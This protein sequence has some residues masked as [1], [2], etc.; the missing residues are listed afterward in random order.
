MKRPLGNIAAALVMLFGFA[1]VTTTT[2]AQGN[3]VY[4][5]DDITGPNT[6]SGFSVASNGTLTPVPGSPFATGG[7]GTGVCCLNRPTIGNVGNFLFTSNTGSNNVSVFSINAGTGAL[8][9]VAGS[10]FATG[11]SGDPFGIALSPTPDGMFLMAANSGSNN[12][13]VFSIAG[14]GALTPIAGSP[15]PTLSIPFGT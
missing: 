13:T 6:V 5:N 14:S 11:G 4:T 9:L 10:P 1:V 3:F 8:S 2:R 15:F 12:L 7:T